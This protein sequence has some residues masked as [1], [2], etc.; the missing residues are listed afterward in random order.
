VKERMRL[1]T[2]E[3]DWHHSPWKTGVLRRR[4]DAWRVLRDNG[5]KLGPRSVPPPTAFIGLMA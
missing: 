5:S 4:V 3:P 2:L 1:R